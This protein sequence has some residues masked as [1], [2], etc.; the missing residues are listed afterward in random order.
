MAKLTKKD[1][2]K[3]K[4]LKAA[5]VTEFRQKFGKAKTDSSK[6]KSKSPMDAKPKA[7]LE[8]S[9]PGNIF[10]KRRDMINKTVANAKRG[11]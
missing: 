6:S 3:A 5:R 11:K 8:S 10:T 7:K 1:K 2:S 4:G 9:K